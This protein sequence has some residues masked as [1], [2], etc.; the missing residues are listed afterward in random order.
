MDSSDVGTSSGSE[1]QVFLSFRGPD[2]RAGFTDFL[3]HS[4]TDAGICVFRDDEEL[5]V[6]ERIDGSLQRVIDN[7]RIYM[8]IFSQNYASSQWCLREIAQI[9]ANTSKSEGNKEILPIFFYVEPDD[10]KL[11]TPLYRDAIQNLE[12][13]K[14][15]SNEQVDAWREAL[16]KVGAIKGWEVKKYKG[17]GEL[18]KLVVEKVVEKLKT[19]H[20]LLTEHLVGIDDR[21]VAVSK[22]LD[23]DSGGV[24]LVQIHGMGGIGKTTLAKVVF[25]Q[26][27]FHFGKCCCFLEDVREKSTRTNGLV[28]LQKKLLSEIGVHAG[29]RSIDE[30]DYG[31]KRIGEALCNKKVFIVLDNVDSSEQVEKLV[32]Q[33]TLHYGSRVLIT[34]R[35]KHV[36]QIKRVKYL[37]LDYEMEV[38]STDHALELFSRHAFNRDS[39]SDDYKDLSKEIISSTGRLPLALEVVGS[40]LYNTTQERWKKTLKKLKKAPHNDVFG[41][42][43]I[44]Y[45]ALS[46]EQ[47]QIFLDIACFFIGMD[48]TNAIYVWEDCGLLRDDEVD[49]LNSMC[50]IKIIED[51]KFWMHDQLRDLG[52]EIVRNENPIN[53][54]K[55]SRLWIYGEILDTITTKEIKRNVQ[56]LDLNLSNSYH[57]NIIE[58]EE[59]GR[60]EQL[61]YLKL[62]GGT[63]V[64]NLANC[65]TELR[66]I[67]WS[68]PPLVSKPTNM[69]LKNVVILEFVE[70]D[71]MDDSML[72]SFVEMVGKLKVLT[73]DSCDNIVRTANFSGCLNL[74]RLT[75]VSCYNLR[76]IDGSIG[77]L[78]QLT[79]LKIDGC[80]RLEDFPEEIGDLSNLRHFSLLKCPVK[81]VP[82]SLW[83]LKSLR[84]VHFI[85]LFNPF[86][87][88]FAWELPSAI[89]M[90]QKLEV[91]QVN[92][93]NLKGQL[94]SDVGSLPFLRILDLSCTHVSEVP[95]TLH[96][97]PCLK[98][99]ELRE[100]NQI[101]ELP[102]LPTS[103]T[104][105]L[106]SSTS[107]RVIPHLS[108]LSNLV[109]LDLNDWGGGGDKLCTDEL[110]WIGRLSKLTKLS[111]GLHNLPVPTE[112]ASLPLLKQLDLFGFDLQNFPQLPLSLQKLRL[113]NFNPIV[114]LSTNMINLSCLGLYRSPMQEFQLN[115]L[116]LPNI[117][118]LCVERCESLERFWLSSMRKLKDVRVSSC[119]KL[120]EIQFS[121]LESLEELSIHHCKSF[122]TLAHVREAR[123]D[124]SE[125][126]NELIS[127]EGRLILPLGFLNKLQSFKLGDCAKI[128]DIEIVGASESLEWFSLSSCP[129]VRSLGGL[130]NLKNL[131]LLYIGFNERLR[132]VTGLDELEFLA[133]LVVKS[134]G[135][136]ERLI[137]VSSTKM[138][139][140]CYIH[141]SGCGKDFRGFLESYKHHTEQEFKRR[142]ICWG[143]TCLSA[144]LEALA[145]NKKKIG[146]SGRNKN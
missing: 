86:D 42:L 12:S 142:R 58:S 36:L 136:L 76:K 125:P 88:A 68:Y 57:K 49:V 109:E 16:M 91:L 29:T 84:E 21:V 65:L 70:N 108:N 69:H 28:E 134:C 34:T 9:V 145:M 17:H 80:F 51:N 22:L 11:K 48:K 5:R 1:Y 53:P 66:W 131:D 90:L 132:V 72:Q 96:M 40:L 38:M 81:K 120:V 33:S 47:Q 126:A 101:Q 75:F 60:F 104:H 24:R 106:V 6:G 39:P 129:N 115:G 45:D 30:I 85:S 100:C 32:G 116:Q 79:D 141:I 35:N 61:R 56:A 146:A 3:Y 107:L 130:S 135:S 105:L 52:R 123:H 98:R 7:S 99:L 124:N 94:P 112:L 31:M 82:D 83:N 122:E 114:S 111:F 25:N 138:P 46:F 133:F 74:E 18:I 113:D 63:F 41:K 92:N 110:W 59:I 55:R 140:D 43:K 89:G 77:K 67:Y 78:K 117:R 128:L 8:P 121:W 144:V 143:R 62:D 137:D 103:L 93:Y 54:G 13:E 15:L 19:K 102:V 2:T 20:R 95:E 37:I 23:I 127:C 87:L 4:L 71:F 73:L 26:N 14:N 64:G 27:S 139:N 97:L 10:I 44:S 50:L 119:K 118:E